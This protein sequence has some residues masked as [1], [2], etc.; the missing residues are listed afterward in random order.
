MCSHPDQGTRI[1]RRCRRWQ[2][3]PSSQ[4]SSHAPLAGDAAPAPLDTSGSH[5]PRINKSPANWRELIFSGVRASAT[6][7]ASARCQAS[8][9]IWASAGLDNFGFEVDR[10]TV[11]FRVQ[12][13]TCRLRFEALFLISFFFLLPCYDV[14]TISY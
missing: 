12:Q 2:G 8:V 1:R 4:C 6:C 14:S 9:K 5:P 7:Q 3:Q 10:S 13:P 11:N